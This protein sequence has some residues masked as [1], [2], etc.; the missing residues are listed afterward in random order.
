MYLY[1]YTLLY[2]MFIFLHYWTIIL[3]F[4]KYEVEGC[5]TGPGKEEMH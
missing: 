2:I 3:K 4:I 1:I 5:K